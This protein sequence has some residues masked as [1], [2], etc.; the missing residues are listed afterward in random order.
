MTNK[1]KKQPSVKI[2]V[3]YHKPAILFKNDVFVPIHLGRALA[4]AASKDGKIS[5]DD[6]QWMLDNMIGDDTGDNISHLNRY[7]AEMTAI[8]WAWK[9][10]DKLGNPDYIGLAHY[11]RMFGA[12]DVKNAINYDITATAN[13]IS[14]TIE[15]QWADNHATDDLDRAIKLL[16]KKD[17]KYARVADEY[18]KQTHGYFYNMFIMKKDMFFEY[19]ETLF[20]ILMKIHDDIDYSSYNAY[21]QRMPAFVAERLT[22]IFVTEKEKKNRVHR[23]H[24]ITFMCPTLHALKRKHLSHRLLSWISFGKLRKKQHQCAKNY[25]DLVTWAVK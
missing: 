3:G 5:T 1:T 25:R 6:Y 11:R 22:G 4:T 15:K 20:G 10:Y 2:L 13:G 18:V 7:F 9:N 12:D 8:Y 21:N 14:A 17:K 24:T 23:V 16:V 19:C